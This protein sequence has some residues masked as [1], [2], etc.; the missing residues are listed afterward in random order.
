MVSC[1]CRLIAVEKEVMI[2]HA[3]L[4]QAAKHDSISLCMMLYTL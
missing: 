1:N 4:D 2:F 3:A